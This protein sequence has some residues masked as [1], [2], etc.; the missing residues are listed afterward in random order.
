MTIKLSKIQNKEK[1]DEDERV[2]ELKNNEEKKE[3]TVK[4]NKSLIGKINNFLLK[5][6][7]VSLKD[8][9]FFV[10]YLG[11]MLRAGISLSIALKTL[12]I[13]T[14]NKKFARII[15]D[16]S[17]SVEKGVSLTESLRPH[18]NVFGE[19]FINMVEAGEL[20][21]KLE[22]VLNQLYVQL[23]KNHELI[24]KVKGALTYPLVIVFAMVGIGIF[25]MIF[26]VPKLTSMLLEF[27][28]ELPL[29]TKI[30]IT[31][32]DALV[33]NGLVS[34][35]G[36]VLFVLVFIKILKTYKGKF[37][38]QAILL[39]MPIISPIIKKINLAKFSRT[40]SS[41]L[42]T[43]IMIIKTFEISANVLG[44]LHYREAI[45]MMGEKIKKG[46]QINEVISLYPKLFPPVV[47]QIVSVGEQTGELDNILT[48]LADFYEGEVNKIMDNLPSIIE[49]ILILAL[50]VGVGGMA[51]AIIMP[52]YSMS[53]AI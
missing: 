8:K 30:L 1:I 21:G 15:N 51:V 20:S 49:P 6:S 12:A 5:F 31:I 16:M 45:L 40:V 14:E 26:I 24:S 43:D 11:I 23:K 9:L 48:E 17:E 32:S 37:F 27:G 4:N 52:M 19:L 13:Q 41:L 38:F 42:K 35:I 18:I 34:L 39:K 50:G 28:S 7:R 53:A 47:E 33:N 25:M 44:N 29:P 3:E 10:Q 36:F 2:E 22:D 46:S